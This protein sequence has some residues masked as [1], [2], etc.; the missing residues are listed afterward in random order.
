[1]AAPNKIPADVK[2]LLTNLHQ[3]PAVTADAAAAAVA[4]VSVAALGIVVPGD[5]ATMQATTPPPPQMVPDDPHEEMCKGDDQGQ[6]Q[7]VVKDKGEDKG[8]KMLDKG[9]LRDDQEKMPENDDQG[10]EDVMPWTANGFFLDD[11][12]NWVP[13]GIRD[14]VVDDEEEVETEESDSGSED[15]YA[16]YVSGHGLC[17]HTKASCSG[18]N[19]APWRSRLLFCEHLQHVLREHSDTTND[20][21]IWTVR[22]LKCEFLCCSAKCLRASHMDQTVLYRKLRWC[23]VCRGPVP[24]RASLSNLPRLQGP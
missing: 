19:R 22:G 21:E 24:H 10:E 13:E 7:K 8:E 17:M 23:K 18:L 9:E 1:M 3:R 16:A 14:Q 20:M 4:A 11:E 6:G 5:T 15:G 12:G 2:D